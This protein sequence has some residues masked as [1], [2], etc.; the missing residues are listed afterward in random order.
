MFFSGKKCSK[1]YWHPSVGVG[2]LS[3]KPGCAPEYIQSFENDLFRRTC[4][5]EFA[6]CQTV[7]CPVENITH[8]SVAD[9]RGAPGTRTPL[10]SN[11]LILM[12]FLAKILQNNSF[13]HPLGIY[14]P[15][16]EILDPTLQSPN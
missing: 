6:H 10:R 4:S 1:N 14:H 8:K 16:W 12:H 15:L 9:P 11:Y 5:V 2:A 13:L 3:L 7:L